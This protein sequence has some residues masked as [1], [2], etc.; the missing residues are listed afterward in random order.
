MIFWSIQNKI[1][2]GNPM[3]GM[4]VVRTVMAG[5]LLL[6][7][8]IAFSGCCCSKLTALEEQTNLAMQKAEAAQRDA[9][10][11]SAKADEAAAQ[12]SAA[13][14]SAEKAEAAAQSAA[15]DAQKAEAVFMKN[16]GK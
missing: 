13:A 12:A 7:L 10:E 9:A 2:G 5:A 4:K 15:K 1:E 8:G 16:M 14:A 6:P 3:N 11:A